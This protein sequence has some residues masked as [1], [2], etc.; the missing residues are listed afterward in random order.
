M[1]VLRPQGTVSRRVFTSKLSTA[2]G[3]QERRSCRLQ[4]AGIK[5]VDAKPC[6]TASSRKL[7]LRCLVRDS[8]ARG[9]G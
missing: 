3:P 1:G 9:G 8:H 6:M 4:A 5:S 2:A 7:L